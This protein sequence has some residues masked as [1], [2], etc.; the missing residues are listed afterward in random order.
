M[1]AEGIEHVED[2]VVLR[3]LGQIERRTRDLRS[4][5]QTSDEA[6][7]GALE[8]RRAVTEDE[9]LLD[10]LGPIVLLLTEH[11]HAAVSAAMFAIA[12]GQQEL[13]ASALSDLDTGEQAALQVGVPGPWW[14]Y[15]LTRHLLGDLAQTSI[16]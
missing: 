7:V 15:R 3:D 5:P 1:V 10:V 6:L 16:S 12:H 13:L 8:G 11:Y 9:D 4:S 14:V 2:V